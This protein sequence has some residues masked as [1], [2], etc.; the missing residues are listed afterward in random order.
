MY[1]L[2]LLS[3]KGPS[4][5]AALTHNSGGRLG[6]GTTHMTLTRMRRKGYVVRKPD[7]AKRSHTGPA[8]PRYELTDAGRRQIKASRKIRKILRQLLSLQL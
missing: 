1:I 3:R 6:S 8:R 4:H 5:C 2:D 7:R